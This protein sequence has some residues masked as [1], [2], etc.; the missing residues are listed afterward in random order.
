[1]GFEGRTMK[2]LKVS[3]NSCEIRGGF[4]ERRKVDGIERD[5]GTVIVNGLASRTK[6]VTD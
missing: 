4:T 2:A 5:S 3:Q 6:R 1:M